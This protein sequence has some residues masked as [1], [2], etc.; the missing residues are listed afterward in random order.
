MLPATRA[1]NQRHQFLTVELSFE[2]LRR[3]LGE[4]VTSLHPLVREVVAGQSEKSAVAPPTRLTSR[5]QQLLAS[6]R[7]APVLALAQ[8][9]WY[10]AKAL[11]DRGGIFLRRAGR[12]GI[13]LPAATTSGRRARGKSG[14]RSAREIGGA[15][16]AGRTRTRGWLQSVS[17]EPDFFDGHGHDDSAIHAAVAIGT[18]GGIIEIGKIQR[19]RGRAGSGLFELEPFQPGISRGVR[20]LSRPLSAADADADD[21]VEING[22]RY[23]RWI[24]MIEG[25]WSLRGSNSRPPQCHCGALPTELRPHPERRVI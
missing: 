14:R 10:Q 8:S 17:F 22:C 3:H 7:E 24:S 25:W 19:H 5:Q 12:A 15:A 16:D 23:T 1:A 9:V 11:E 4:F 20:L 21:F 6:L 18:R 2:F 13:V